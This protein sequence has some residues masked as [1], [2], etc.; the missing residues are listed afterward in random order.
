MHHASGARPRVTPVPV[1]RLA[2]RL[3]PAP[4]RVTPVPGTASQRVSVHVAGLEM[5][6]PLQGLAELLAASYEAVPIGAE[7]QAV[8]DMDASR[9][10][11][12]RT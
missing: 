6:L 5:I 10:V 3:F 9:K 8:V 2:S 7:H 4:P 1:P 12:V 11:R